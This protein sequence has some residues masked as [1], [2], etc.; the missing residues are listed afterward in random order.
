[1]MPGRKIKFFVFLTLRLT[2]IYGQFTVNLRSIGTQKIL[3]KWRFFAE[4]IDIKPELRYYFF[5]I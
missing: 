3:T 1:M 4:I 2:L 5:V